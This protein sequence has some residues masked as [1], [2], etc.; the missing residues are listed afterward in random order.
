MLLTMDQRLLT[1][2]NFSLI[3]STTFFYS[4]GYLKTN[5]NGGECKMRLYK[6]SLDTI[7]I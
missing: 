5:K 3:P 7:Y 6:C 1:T 4:T 2:H